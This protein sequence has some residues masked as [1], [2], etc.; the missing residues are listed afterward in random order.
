MGDLIEPT[1]NDLGFGLV[2]VRV[3]GS[4]NKRTLQV[5]AEPRDAG[6]SMTV[7]D[8]AR[9]SRAV[10]AVLDVAD[11]IAGHYLLEVSSPGIDRP[12]VRPEDFRR[13]SG[14]E[15]RLELDEPVEG[16]RRFRGRLLGVE[17]GEGGGAVLLDA[18]L[19][20]GGERETKRL[21]FA[22]IRKARLVVTDDLL[23]T[24]ALGRAPGLKAGA[25]RRA[26]GKD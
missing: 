17:E 9:I 13:F 1:L 16:Q 2:L 19:V 22:A 5:M 10:S 6:A 25:P 20:E 18:A 7:D 14:F 21:P 24:G 3:L 12:L 4:G 8:C 15:A 26:P 23:K 11:P